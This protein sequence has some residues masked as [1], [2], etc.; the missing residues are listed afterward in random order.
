MGKSTAEPVSA[1]SPIDDSEEIDPLNPCFNAEQTLALGHALSARFHL[2]QTGV[3]L[4]NEAALE[5]SEDSLNVLKRLIAN[6]E[7]EIQE[8]LVGA[9]VWMGEME[10]LELATMPYADYLKTDHWQSMREMALAISAHRCQVC[11]SPNHLHVHH[12]TYENRGNEQSIDLT[13]LCAECH[14]LFHENR[15][16]V[17]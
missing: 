16:L 5:C 12:R 15:K 2:G 4:A 10:I 8:L 3:E 6:N 11:N 13:V 7:A 14:Q 1:L 17:K 9:Y